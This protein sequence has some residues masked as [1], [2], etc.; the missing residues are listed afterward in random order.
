MLM[1]EHGQMTRNMKQI[2]WMSI[3]ICVLECS[4][5]VGLPVLNSVFWLNRQLFACWHNP[6][7]D[8]WIYVLPICSRKAWQTKCEVFQPVS[9]HFGFVSKVKVVELHWCIARHSWRTPK[10]S[11][12]VSA[13]PGAYPQARFENCHNVI[14]T[15]MSS[16]ERNFFQCRVWDWKDVREVLLC[17]CELEHAHWKY[18]KY[19]CPVQI[20]SGTLARFG[21]LMFGSHQQVQ[22]LMHTLLE[23]QDHAIAL[24]SFMQV[25]ICCEMFWKHDKPLKCVE[26]NAAT[27][28]LWKM[29]ECNHWFSQWA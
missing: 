16:N 6:M 24:N 22:M 2:I 11:M 3:Y 13:V 18:R 4:R 21:S 8:W 28:Q 23:F 17:F 14:A 5:N 25:S 19:M 1:T 10:V 9:Q 26:P 20:H 29:T 7:C 15:T 12:Q 27:I